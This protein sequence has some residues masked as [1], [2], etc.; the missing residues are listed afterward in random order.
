MTLDGKQIIVTGG[1]KGMGAALARDLVAQGAVVVALD[2]DEPSA[3]GAGDADTGG[4]LRFLRCDVADEAAV[5]SAMREGHGWMGGLW[6]LVHAAGMATSAPAEAFDLDTWE[7]IFAVNARG[8]F[9]TNRAAF[10]M[11][12]QAGGRILNFATAA[13]MTGLRGKAHYAATKGAVLG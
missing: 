7:R 4:A 11:L 1:A 8:T 6:G 2:I 12:R 13:G 9:L 5:Q 3:D 10:P